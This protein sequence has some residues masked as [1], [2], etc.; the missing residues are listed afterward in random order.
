MDANVVTMVITGL[1]ALV[2]VGLTITTIF[3]TRKGWQEREATRERELSS[4]KRVLV[5]NDEITF[6]QEDTRGRG[7]VFLDALTAFIIGPKRM[8]HEPMYSCMIAAVFLLGFLGL[9]L[10]PI[11][12]SVFSTSTPD[13]QLILSTCLLSSGSTCLYGL[14]MGTPF[15]LWGRLTSARVPIDIRRCYRVGALGIP[16]IIMS[17]SYI[18]VVILQDVPIRDSMGTAILMAFMCLGMLFQWLRFLMEIRRI[19]HALSMLIKQE[20]TRRTL[21]AGID[22]LPPSSPRG[23]SHHRRW[24]V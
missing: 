8:D 11:P 10:G 1:G 3:S 17:L 4:A 23:D 15:G 16:T 14:A 12:P 5:E 7:T 20:I 19:N 18:I 13:V 6:P 2:T 22:E 9:V 24:W 21:A